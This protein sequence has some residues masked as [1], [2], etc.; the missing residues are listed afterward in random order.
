LSTPSGPPAVPGATTTASKGRGRPKGAPPKIHPEIPA[1]EFVFEDI[2]QEQR[3]YLRRQRVERSAQQKA[4]DRGVMEVFQDW[5]TAGS[6]GKWGLMPIKSWLI[7][8]ALSEEAELMLRKA[9]SLHDLKLVTGKTQTKTMP[10]LPLPEGKVRIPFCV[11]ARKTEVTG[12]PAGAEVS[13][14]TSE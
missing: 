12:L 8:K 3:G 6:P 9:A 2:S 13:E 14:N 11:V 5:K 10:D 1:S 7:S 4:V